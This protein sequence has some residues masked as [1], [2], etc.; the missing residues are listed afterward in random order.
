MLLS[1]IHVFITAGFPPK[2]CGICDRQKHAGPKA[3]ILLTKPRHNLRDNAIIPYVS[4]G[5]IPY[6]PD[7]I[8]PSGF[9]RIRLMV[10]R[11]TGS[12]GS[13]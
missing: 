3:G 13:A 5:I 11:I 10:A 2:A 12:R 1:G 8:I 7:G 4:D 6:V 9:D